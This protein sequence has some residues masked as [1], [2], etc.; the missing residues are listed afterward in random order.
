MR[1]LHEDES[2]SATPS[3]NH[4]FI[5]IGVVFFGI[6]STL[7]DRLD[8]R[9]L[10]AVDVLHDEAKGVNAVLTVRAE[11]TYPAVGTVKGGG[12]G[13]GSL[14]A[15]KESLCGRCVVKLDTVHSIVV[16]VNPTVLRLVLNRSRQVLTIAILGGTC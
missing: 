8:C 5:A 13:L 15:D 11:E 10:C 12:D 7:H 3:H 14:V 6:T 9:L 2:A 4:E 16:V 1:V